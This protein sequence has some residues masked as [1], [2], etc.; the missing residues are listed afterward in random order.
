MGASW[1]LFRRRSV[2]SRFLPVGWTRRSGHEAQLSGLAS[3]DRSNVA[4]TSRATRTRA[5]EDNV[6]LERRSPLPENGSD[7]GWPKRR[8][9]ADELN[10]RGN[11]CARGVPL[12]GR[13]RVEFLPLT[14]TATPVSTATEQQHD[15]NDNQ[16]QFHGNSPLM[17][18]ALFAAYQSIQQRLQ[19]IVP[20]K[21]STPQLAL[22]Q[23]E[24]FR[25]VFS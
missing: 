2:P 17:A 12:H 10:H 18:M 9:G 7:E 13:R 14:S 19:S 3:L 15:H 25:S 16:N 22:R 21:R 8:I 20:D 4:A 24:Q 23:R 6:T 5:R 11:D 1:R